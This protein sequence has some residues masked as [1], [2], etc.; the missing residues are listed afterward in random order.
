MK[1][2]SGVI[3]R[4]FIEG[5]EGT[6]IRRPNLRR[7]ARDNGVPFIICQGKWL[8]DEDEFFE[9]INPQ[10]FI[11]RQTLPRL[12]SI[13]GC[14]REYNEGKKQKRKLIDRHVVEKVMQ[15]ESVFKY[16]YGNKWYINYD[17]IEP[18]LKAFVMEREQKERLKRNSKKR[19]TN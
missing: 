3:F 16:Y 7:F 10:G 19:K 9:K 1:V 5:D 13:R 6:I 11:E 8:V 2:S 14:V 4:K 18:L 12:R 15:D 17:Q